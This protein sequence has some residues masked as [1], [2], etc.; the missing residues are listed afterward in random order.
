MRGMP[1]VVY[2][3]VD[4]D[5]A[6]QI[7]HQHIGRGLLVNDHIYDKPTADLLQA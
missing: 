1:P 6:R 3:R 7:V 2:G 4:E 5:T